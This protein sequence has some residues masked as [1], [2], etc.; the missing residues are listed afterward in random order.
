M[1]CNR[2]QSGWGQVRPFAISTQFGFTLVEMLVALALSA[3]VAAAAVAALT[4]ARQGFNAV[5]ASSQ[6]RDNGRFASELIQR[7]GVQSGYQDLTYAG[8]TRGSEFA[9]AGGATNPI[10][11][12]TGVDNA[13]VKLSLVPDL[14]SAYI[15]RTSAT[16][17]VSGCT[18]ATDTACANGSDVL[19][20]RYQSSPMNS[21]STQSDG[22]MINC[23]GISP[24]LAPIS[25][26]DQIVSILHVS[27]SSNGEPSLMCTYQDSAGGWQSQPIVQGVES[28]QV[29]Y[30]IDGFSSTSASKI[31]QVFNGTQDTVPDKYLAARD[32]VKTSTPSN[33]SASELTSVDTYNNWRRVRSLRIGLV[34]RGPTNSAID[35]SAT[36]IS[37]LCSLS[38][39]PDAATNCIDQGDLTASSMGSEFPRGATVSND[40]RLRQTLTFT[41]FLR[42]VQNQ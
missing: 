40:G 37:K 33:P 13:I 32:I 7:L 16:S 38:V 19:I 18:S 23:A 2:T 5:D 39:N 35:K 10:P 26:D 34:L 21:S 3:I 14:T 42:N 1:S 36:Y 4:I 41:V 12:I 8:A 22:S 30:G 20:L 11:N 24:T 29:L 15:K 17:S 27:R 28:F 25:K 31:N 9:V 6:L